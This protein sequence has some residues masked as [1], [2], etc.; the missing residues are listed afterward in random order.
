MTEE[1][2]KEYHFLVVDD[3]SEVRKVIREYLEAL[4]YSLITEA[5]DGTE[6]LAIV[7]KDMSINFV[8]SDWDMPYMSG[9]NL[10]QHI[11][12]HPARANIPFLMITSPVSHEAEKVILAAENLVD[13]YLIKPFRSQ[14]LFQK[15][16]DVLVKVVHGPQK[17]VVVIDD[18]P[19]AR[20]MVI[21]YVQKMGFREVTGLTNGKEG[22]NFLSQNAGDVGLIICDWEMPEMGG[23]EVLKA[24]KVHK[25]LGDIP[26]LMITS[27]TSIER[28]KVL[29]AAKAN[30]DDYLLKPFSVDQIRKRVEGLIDKSRTR[31]EVQEM[32]SQAF[33]HVEHGRYQP[34]AELFEAVLSLDPNY[35]VVL[36]GYGDLL[37]KIKGVEV[38][39]P[40]YKRAI[41]ANKANPKGYVKLAM[42]YEQVGLLDKAI[43]LLQDSVREISF[44]A[45][46]HFHLGR[47]FNKK[48]LYDLAKAEFEKT[49]ELQLDHTEARLMLEML[50]GGKKGEPV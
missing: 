41:D 20:E 9:L 21:E 27:Q 2:T 11:R 18:D 19:D 28:M 15:I 50:G 4:G 29:Q 12:S 45:D 43:L 24:C 26:F 48:K 13:T 44:S 34:A 16:Q 8:I 42:A 46:L 47:L 32:T 49:L 39:L 35:D 33:V 31:K 30:V 3:D 7:K 17:R 14:A 25:T 40:Y 23:I 1:P 10:L 38:A 36:R 5:S 22:L 37:I 6:A